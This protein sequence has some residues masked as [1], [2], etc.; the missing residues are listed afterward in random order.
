MKHVEQNDGEGVEVLPLDVGENVY[1]VRLDRVA[2]VVRTEAV[3]EVADG[4]VL[5]LPDHEIAV[6]A[7]ARVLGEDAAGE[8]AI[9]VLHGRDDHGRVPGWLVDAVRESETVADVERTVG[10]VRHVRGRV[11]VDG[12]AAVLV[13]PA[14]IF[15]R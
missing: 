5:E 15:G 8:G 12:E 13:D 1:A 6:T 14:K 4:D 2:T 9:V 11:E 10:A 7:A 3:A